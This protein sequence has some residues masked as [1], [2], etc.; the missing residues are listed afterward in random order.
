M[1]K[2]NQKFFNAITFFFDMAIVLFSL[3]LSY[4]IRFKTTLFGPIGTTLPIHMYIIF[5]ICLVIPTY[6]ITYFIFGMYDYYRSKKTVPEMFTIIKANIISFLFMVSVLFIIHQPDFSR[7][8][9]LLL[10]IFGIVFTTI[11]KTMLHLFLRSIRLKNKNLKH[12]LVIGNDELAFRYAKI[13]NDNK[14]MGY[15]INGFIGTSNQID[16]VIYDIPFIGTFENVDR[17]IRN[18]SFDIVVIA[19]NLKFYEHLNEIV[20]ICEKN[21]VKSE[22]IPDYY[23][24]IPAKASVDMIDDLPI[25]NIREV[26]LNAPINKFIKRMSDVFISIAILIVTSPLFLIVTLII[27]FTSSNSVIFK[28]TRVGFNGNEFIMYKFRSMINVDNEEV[29]WTTSDDDRKTRFGSFI[30]KTSIDELPQFFNVL[31]GDMSIIGPR[32]ERPYFV[33]EFRKTIPKY[34]V[35]HQVKPGMTGLAQIKG[36]RGNTSIKKRIEYDIYYVENWNL[37]L[38]LII[39]LKTFIYLGKNAY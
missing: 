32:P 15:K 4:Y 38:D 20:D 12:I 39:F 7:K 11:E 6:A 28:Q 5:T 24:Y 27:K 8:M 36:C 25:I 23:K 34:M 14:H 30:R 29:R 13:I 33:N 26:P 22:I 16:D 10:F 19:I 37:T 31:K 17:I 1:I 9:L 3:I 21:G 2:E 35:K 18:N